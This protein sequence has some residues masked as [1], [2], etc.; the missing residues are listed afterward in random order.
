MFNLKNPIT[1]KRCLTSMTTVSKVYLDTVI[2]NKLQRLF[3][4]LFGTTLGR[5]TEY[6]YIFMQ[7]SLLFKIYDHG[8]LCNGRSITHKN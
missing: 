3:K 2:I 4:N 7:C 8:K 5:F 1:L 6:L